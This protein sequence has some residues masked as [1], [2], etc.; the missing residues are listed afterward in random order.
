MVFSRLRGLSQDFWVR[1][2]TSHAALHLLFELLDIVY[3][4]A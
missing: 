1:H 4:T 3:T 2:F